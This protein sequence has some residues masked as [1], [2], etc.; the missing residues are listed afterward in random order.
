MGIRLTSRERGGAA[1]GR[2]DPGPIE[3]ASPPSQ[4]VQMKSVAN[5]LGSPQGAS[6]SGPS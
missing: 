4:G 2:G 6:G 3:V 5:A 1:R